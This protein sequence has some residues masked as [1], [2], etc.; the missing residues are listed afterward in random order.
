[1]IIQI[2]KSRLGNFQKWWL[3]PNTQEDRIRGCLIGGAG[4]FW[5]GGL[6]RLIFGESPVSIS[7]IGL[8]ALGG[9]VTGI[10]LG[11]IFPKA[12]SC[13]C[14]PFSKFGISP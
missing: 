6:G 9:A 2:L 10:L 8:W 4:C 11:A 3:A 14:F 7:V 12:V 1:M 13:V 5:I